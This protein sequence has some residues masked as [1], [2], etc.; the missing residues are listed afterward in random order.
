MEHDDPDDSPDP[1]ETRIEA[2]HAE[3][4]Q[5]MH[6]RNARPDDVDVKNRLDT[7]FVELRKLQKEYADRLA[8]RY[9]AR[10]DLPSMKDSEDFKKAMELVE[11]Y[12]NRSV[13]DAVD[14]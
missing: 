11:Y 7:V 8:V 6:E 1:I 5:F 4:S 13:G 2:G 12:E 9:H 14:G 3:I 10:L